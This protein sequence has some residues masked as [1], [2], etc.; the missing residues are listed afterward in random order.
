M[1]GYGRAVEHLGPDVAREVGNRALRVLAD[2]LED[3]DHICTFTPAD[4]PIGDGGVQAAVNT[5]I[6]DPF[7]A[8]TLTPAVD[9]PHIVR[10]ALPAR[11]IASWRRPQTWADGTGPR[12]LADGLT[13]W[14]VAHL[15]HLWPADA[16]C[17]TVR[18]NESKVY[19]NIYLDLAVRV[20]DRLWLLHLGVCD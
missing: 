18:V 15:A 10:E 11:F 9:W 2:L 19:E 12:R 20:G 16:D 3:T 17:W 7:H 14:I 4:A 8:E 1:T 5:L 6:A 13:D